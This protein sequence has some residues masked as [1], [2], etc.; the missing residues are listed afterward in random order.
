LKELN[1][2]GINLLMPIWLIIVWLGS[3]WQELEQTML[4]SSGFLTL[5]FKARIMIEMGLI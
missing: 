5:L 2:F 3:G 4:P 1:T